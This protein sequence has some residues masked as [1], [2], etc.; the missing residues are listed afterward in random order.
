MNFKDPKFRNSI[1]IVTYAILLGYILLNFPIV[2]NLFKNILLILKPFMYAIG[3][4][5]V[6]NI[7]MKSF[8]ENIFGFMKSSNSSLVRHARRPLS[9]FF[10][11]FLLIGFISTLVIFVIP[12]LAHSVATLIRN[13]PIYLSKIEAIMRE[14]SNSMSILSTLWNEIWAMWKELLQVF[15]QTLSII[16]SHILNITVNV[17]SSI[18]NFILSI[19]LSV[20]MLANKETLIFQLKRILYANLK[21]TIV[22]KIL[23]IGSLTDRMFSRFICGQCTEAL[24]IGLLCFIG[25]TFMRMPYSFLI[26]V[27]IGVTSL[28]PILGAFIGTIPSAF[29]LFIMHPMQALIFLIFIILLQQ[30][31]GDFIYPKVVGNSIG[32]SALWVIFAMIV[33]GKVLGILGMILGIPL[34]GVFYTLL[35]SDTNKKLKKKNISVK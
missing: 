11:L 27:L 6:I 16:V 9:I 29:I 20:Y 19:I 17:T 22:K 7:P 3:I 1:F 32:L 5:F 4:A 30:I 12:E 26:S 15:G 34:F 8:E 33:G 21:E 28:I 13:L 10:T 31:E 14:N 23:Y 35:K 18:I 24:I 2:F 25:M